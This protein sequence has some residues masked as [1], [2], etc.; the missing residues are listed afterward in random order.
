MTDR[1][2]EPPRDWLQPSRRGRTR[3]RLKSAGTRARRTAPFIG[4]ILA[5]FIA[6]A[7]Y[8]ALF[9]GPRPLTQRDVNVSVAS[10]LASQTPPPAFSQ[11]VYEQVQP[12]LVLIETDS[13]TTKGAAEHGLGTGV[14][15]DAS[16]S[17]L[18]AL[19]V[20][21]GASTIHLTFADGTKAAGTVTV[22]RPE[23]DIAV[24]QPDNPPTGLTP[25]TLG[26][27]NA[28][29]VGSEAFVIGNPYGLYSS[30][31]A[32]VVSGLGR[33]FQEPN[34]DQVIHG[35][36]QVDA[37]VNPGN[38][39]GPLLNRSGQVVGIVTGLVNPTKQ[40]VFIGIGLAVP[41]DV[42]GSAAGLPQY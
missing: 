19:H 14:I 3:E 28:L 18:T 27:P 23:T 5:A 40:D 11:L 8:G 6:V 9:P 41:I 33:S 20:V 15:V 31:S 4:G 25:A 42:A 1:E 32:G 36:I 34:S 29:Q 30:I 12:A 17:I 7:L 39:G 38:S 24:V 26:N 10:A 2:S 35:L 37:A 22:R 16:G 21:D 13:T